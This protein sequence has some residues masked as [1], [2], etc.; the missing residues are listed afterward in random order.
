MSLP[1]WPKFLQIKKK[2]VKEICFPS[3]LLRLAKACVI[4]LLCVS[5][6]PGPSEPVSHAAFWPASPALCKGLAVT[7]GEK[8]LWGAPSLPLSNYQHWWVITTNWFYFLLCKNLIQSRLDS[9]IGPE[10]IMRRCWASLNIEGGKGRG[11]GVAMSF[12]SLGHKFQLDCRALFRFRNRRAGVTFLCELL[13]W[14]WVETRAS[15][16]RPGW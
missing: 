14:G 13:T 1:I 6:H 12:M 8:G 3:C 9:Q 7:L 11:W 4:S 10:G 5:S 15:P 16:T 2:K